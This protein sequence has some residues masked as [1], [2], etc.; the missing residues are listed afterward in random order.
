MSN[1]ASKTVSVASTSCAATVTINPRVKAP[2]LTL[3]WLKEIS[4]F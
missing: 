2:S 4:G 1:I 3:S